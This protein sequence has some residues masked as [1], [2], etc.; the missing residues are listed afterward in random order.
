MWI[1]RWIQLFHYALHKRTQREE[2]FMNNPLS[3]VCNLI[4]YEYNLR[5]RAF[6]DMA[7][8]S[9]GV[10]QCFRSVYCLQNL[11][12]ESTISQKALIFILTDVRT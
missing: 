8:C 7:P 9:L 3:A 6:W 10:D 2:S 11:S 12:N 5:I 4:Q 1:G